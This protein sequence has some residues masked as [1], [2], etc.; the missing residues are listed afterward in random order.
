[1][2]SSFGQ[3]HWRPSL[4]EFRG[5]FLGVSAKVAFRC[6]HARPIWPA[7]C[8]RFTQHL[9]WEELH[10]LADLIGQPHCFSAP[11][12]RPLA[13]AALWET[14]RDAES[15]AQA[16]SAAIIVGAANNW[17]ARFHDRMPVILDWRDAGA[18]LTDDE[19]EQLLKPQPED[20]LQEWSV[21]SRVNKSGVGDDDQS[22]IRRLILPER[23]G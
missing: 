21:S 18:W 22:L 8:G 16:D 10:R 17:M 19:P 2:V 15:D 12:G 5:L 14:W 20:G 1:M 6:I 11:D 23:C 7:M 9:S 13:F 3:G 4:R